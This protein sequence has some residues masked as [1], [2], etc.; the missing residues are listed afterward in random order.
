MSVVF[1]LTFMRQGVVICLLWQSETSRPLDV[2]KGFEGGTFALN[3]SN[4][5]NK[6]LATRESNKRPL[7]CLFFSFFFLESLWG[8]PSAAYSLSL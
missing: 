3:E 2:E 1:A 4:A 5:T 6:C 8:S 7:Y